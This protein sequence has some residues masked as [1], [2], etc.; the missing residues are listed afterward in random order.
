MRQTPRLDRPGVARAVCGSCNRITV[1]TNLLPRQPL[2]LTPP[3]VAPIPAMKLA[4][5]IPIRRNELPP[6]K[7]G[8]AWELKLV[9]GAGG[10]G[11][12]G[13]R[14]LKWVAGEEAG[15]IY[16]HSHRLSNWS[17]QRPHRYLL[18]DGA[19]GMA[20]I[21]KFSTTAWSRGCDGRQPH[22]CV[23]PIGPDWATRAEASGP[24]KF[25]GSPIGATRWPDRQLDYLTPRLQ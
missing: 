23:A 20:N 19:E 17:A 13:R 8:W 4:P 22:G 25:P 14:E 2:L 6:E 21:M 15:S 3:V 12:V 16:P 5:I 10:S 7:D 18:R 1:P 24:G 11:M 9:Q